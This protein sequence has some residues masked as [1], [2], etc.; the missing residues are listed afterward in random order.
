MARLFKLSELDPLK[1]HKEDC[2]PNVLNY[3]HLLERDEAF[4]FANVNDQIMAK[5]IIDFLNHTYGVNHKLLEIYNTTDEPTPDMVDDILDEQNTI[6][7]LDDQLKNNTVTI[8]LFLGKVN[9]LA[10]FG[11]VNHQVY[12]IDVQ[13]GEQISMNDPNVGL[14]LYK[15]NEIY[16]F[17]TEGN[18]MTNMK[19]RNS[20][21][22]KKNAYI[23]TIKQ[24][25]RANP[26][27]VRWSRYLLQHSGLVPSKKYKI[28]NKR[29]NKSVVNSVFLRF[30][31]KNAVFEDIVVPTAEHF[32]IEIKPKSRSRSFRSLRSLKSK[33]LSRSRSKH[34]I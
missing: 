25:I 30:E 34:S 27:A 10:L 24:R 20:S 7:F 29:T 3:L 15:F 9:H 6:D 22:F 28:I 14:Y 16:L 17:A 31:S 21:R 33:S 8:A 18:K 2:V 19:V 4:K 1:C 5:H 32:F 23:Y 12:I 11:K 26:N 13:T